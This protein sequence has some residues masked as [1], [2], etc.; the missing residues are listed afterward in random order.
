M[1]TVTIE[2]GEFKFHGTFDCGYAGIYRDDMIE[3]EFENLKSIQKEGLQGKDLS[4]C[5]ND[6]I[7]AE[8]SAFFNTLEAKVQR[9]IQQF[10]DTFLEYLFDDLQGCAYPFWE[11]PQMVNQEFMK[12]HPDYEVKYYSHDEEDFSEKISIPSAAGERETQ[13]RLKYP[14]FNFDYYLS[15]LTPHHLLVEKRGYFQFYVSDDMDYL[16]QLLGGVQD[17][18]SFYD[19]NNR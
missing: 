15:H 3:F 10:N 18:L 2:N 13:L 11:Y 9:N 17:D 16:C 6:E 1:V 7:A 4:N 19:W 12:A 5:S 14:S 8:V